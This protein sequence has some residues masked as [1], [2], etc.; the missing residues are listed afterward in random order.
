MQQSIDPTHPSHKQNET[1]ILIPPP[2]FVVYPKTGTRAAIV[3]RPPPGHKYVLDFATS[4][5]YACTSE[6]NQ[7]IK[8]QD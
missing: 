7:T 5:T 4:V 1:F 6:S 3:H 8:P 2:P